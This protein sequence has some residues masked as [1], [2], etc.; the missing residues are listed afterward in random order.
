MRRVI[1]P[2]V[3][4]FEVFDLAGPLQVLHEANQAGAQYELVFAGD[5]RTI[6]SRQGVSLTKLRKLPRP[7]ET[8]VIV[9]PGSSVLRE[10]RRASHAVLGGWLRDAHDSGAT[11][12]S[13]CVGAFLLGR[14]GLLDGR[15]CTTHWKRV[16]ELAR[17]FPR[18]RVMPDRLFV[19]DGRVVTSAGIA[20]GVDMTLALVEE[21]HGPKIAATVAREMVI[22]VRR[23]GAESQLNPLLGYRDH[24]DSGVHAVQD[25]IVNQP[26]E[27][28]TLDELARVAG[29]SR[30]NLTRV[31]RTLIGISV[32]EYH[33]TIRLEHARALLANPQLTVDAVAQRC[34]LSDARHLRRLWKEAFGTSLRPT[35]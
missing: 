7:R 29:M 22:H 31:F 32:A 12:A 2:I 9:V 20:A 13:V 26:A 30:R 1:F 25:A 34:G 35:V 16:D 5:A 21:H 10:A 4:D 6:D 24:F 19:F 23:N 14:A 15:S 33:N 18:A 28:H 27:R 17:R 11:V 3:E 8:D